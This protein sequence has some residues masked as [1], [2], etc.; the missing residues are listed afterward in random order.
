MG[1][2]GNGRKSYSVS[3]NDYQI[4]EE[5]GDGAN[6]VVYSAIYIPLNEI[7]AVKC[8]DL[9]RFNN[10]LVRSPLFVLLFFVV[11]DFVDFNLIAVILIDTWFLNQYGT[12]I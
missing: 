3:R 5:V 2:M 6:A 8:L 10:N 9:D 4:L 7:V 12:V 1:S 11:E